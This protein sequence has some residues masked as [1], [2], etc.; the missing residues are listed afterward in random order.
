MKNVHKR[1]KTLRTYLRLEQ[2]EFCNEIE[3]SQSNLSKIENEKTDKVPSSVLLNILFKYNVDAKWLNGDIGTDDVPTFIKTVDKSDYD[4][5]IKERNE[6]RDKL[7]TAQ[8]QLL[9]YQQKQIDNLK[10]IGSF[11]E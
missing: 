10:N 9:S 5:V 3:I 7:I 2:S 8:E 4:N 11:S 1:I 6:Y